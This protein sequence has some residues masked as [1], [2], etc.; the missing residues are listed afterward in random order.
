MESQ[1]LRTIQQNIAASSVRP[2]FADGI[3][4]AHTIK[5]TKEKGNKKPEKEAHVHLVF[6][7]MTSQKP[8]DKVVISRITARELHRA[9]GDSLDKLEKELKSNKVEKAEKVETDYIR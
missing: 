7:D 5:S 4:V 6:L 1:T 9:L 8:M 3:V 2:L